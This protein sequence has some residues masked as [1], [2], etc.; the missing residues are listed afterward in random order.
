[1]S[2]LDSA[3][4]ESELDQAWQLPSE[5]K[6]HRVDPPRSVPEGLDVL[7]ACGACT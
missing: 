4:G 5:D 3:P 6:G 7:R 2:E 1:M